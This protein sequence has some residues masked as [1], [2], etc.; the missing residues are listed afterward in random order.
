MI[1]DT[2]IVF[3]R[4]RFWLLLAV[5]IVNYICTEIVEDFPIRASLAQQALDAYPVRS[6]VQIPRLE[7]ALASPHTPRPVATHTHSH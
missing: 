5:L 1:S 7:R 3:L 4:E 6:R 2:W